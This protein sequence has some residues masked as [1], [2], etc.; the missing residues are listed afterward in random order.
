MLFFGTANTPTISIA[1]VASQQCPQMD[2]YPISAIARIC[3]GLGEI[4]PDSKDF[5]DM[6]AVVSGWLLA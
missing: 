1:T 5:R 2:S 6:F 4:P 3:L